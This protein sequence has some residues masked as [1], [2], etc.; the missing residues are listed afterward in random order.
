MEI[1]AI[2]EYLNFIIA[3][4]GFTRITSSSLR[5]RNL[6]YDSIDY[7]ID[8]TN[9]IECS[10]D[11]MKRDFGTS[12]LKTTIRKN[13]GRIV[14]STRHF[15]VKPMMYSNGGLRRKSGVKS[16]AT[17]GLYSIYNKVKNNRFIYT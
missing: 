13:P 10:N 7:K 11:T 2:I 14:P 4:N 1:I 6:S 15:S 8:E 9:R 5:G 16:P 17:K 3:I 12:C